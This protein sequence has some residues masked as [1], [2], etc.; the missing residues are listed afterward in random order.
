M[1]FTYTEVGRTRND[2]LP[3]GYRHVRRHAV[4]GQG[5]A[6]FRAVV[7]GMRDF[8]IHRL[9]GMRIRTH[10]APRLGSEFQTGLGFS[11][12]RLW[13]PCRIVWFIDTPAAYG[14]GFGTMPGHP[15]RGEEAFEVTLRGNGE[16]HFDIRAFSSPA[17][18]Y[19]RLGGPVTTLVQSW[20][21][22]RYLASAHKLASPT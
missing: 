14:Y 13:V 22:D 10:G 20:A 3:A 21:T 8:G 1:S 19:A 12:A 2:D 17:S 7:A 11:K 5:D 18:W 16:V 9:A 6:T 15:E 4:V